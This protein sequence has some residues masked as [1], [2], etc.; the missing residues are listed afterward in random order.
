MEKVYGHGQSQFKVQGYKE[1]WHLESDDSG[2]NN[3]INRDVYKNA[4]RCANFNAMPLTSK[5]KGQHITMDYLLTGVIIGFRTHKENMLLGNSSG[6]MIELSSNTKTQLSRVARRLG[7][8][9]EEIA[10]QR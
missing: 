7:L 2:K 6:D 4:M 8:P 3:R 10:R 9:L 5:I 1:A